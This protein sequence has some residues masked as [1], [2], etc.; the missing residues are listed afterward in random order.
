MTNVYNAFLL[1]METKKLKYMK[2]VDRGLD[3]EKMEVY[4]ELVTKELGIDNFE[5]FKIY[6]SE[7]Q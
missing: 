5:I 4:N 6:D 1:E 3:L 2:D 7:E